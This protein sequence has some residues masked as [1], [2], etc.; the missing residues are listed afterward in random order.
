[1]LIVKEGE[2]VRLL[3]EVN[4]ER[5]KEDLFHLA[6]DPL[7]FRKLNFTLPG[8]EKNTLYEA[9]DYI[10]S[11]LEA[12]SYTVWEEGCEVQAFRPGALKPR[13]ER[14]HPD[15]PWY[16]AYNLYAERRGRMYPDEIILLLSHKDSQSWIDSPGAY[17]NAVGTVANMEIARVLSDYEPKRTI[18]FLFCNEEHTPWTSI[19]AAK[20]AR[21]RGDNLIAVINIDS[22]G[23]KSKDTI[24]VGL[25]TN[26][27][28]Y[29]TP[30]GERLA[31]LMLELNECYRIGLAQ[32]KARR[33]R[34]GDDDG[35]FIVEGFSAAVMNVGSFPYA[36]PC[37]HRECDEPGRVDI[38]NVRL[39]TQLT[40]AGCLYLDAHGLV[41]QPNQ[42][43]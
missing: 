7:P 10:R 4:A 40:L 15:D 11:Q 26:V 43:P 34:P 12:C 32:S 31:D 13:F 28:L 16:V 42:T 25:K 1:M 38:I 9:D 33:E 21:E 39:A 20:N 2:I 23:G 36:D 5:M 8:H 30:E 29:T 19:T 35:S 27:T 37:Y 22:L 14:P 3:E 41:Y 6:E 17:D 18:R 24:E